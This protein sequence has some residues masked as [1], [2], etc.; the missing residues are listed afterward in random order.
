[1]KYIIIVF[2]NTH[3]A[4]QTEKYLKAHLPLES[5]PIPRGLSSNCGI[6][7]KIELVEKQRLLELMQ[8]CETEPEMYHMYEVTL[9][10]NTAEVIGEITM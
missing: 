5:I 7:I 10:G 2:V 9:N 3:S 4:I 6:S 8:N 1:M